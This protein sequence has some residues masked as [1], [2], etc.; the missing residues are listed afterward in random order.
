MFFM[1]HDPSEKHSLSKLVKLYYWR[2]IK[3][4]KILRTLLQFLGIKV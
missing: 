4:K 2:N 1:N 3:I